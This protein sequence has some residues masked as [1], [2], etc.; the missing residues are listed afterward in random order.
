MYVTEN[1]P[2][3]STIMGS[4]SPRCT[5]KKRPPSPPKRQ[6]SRAGDN[7]TDVVI[8]CSGPVPK[9]SSSTTSSANT[10]VVTVDLHSTAS[11][12]PSLSLPA[13]PSG[14]ELTGT[15]DDELPLPPPPAPSSPPA[16]G[17]REKFEGLT[18]NSSPPTMSRS[19]GNV[20]DSSGSSDQ[21]SSATEQEL[22][23]SLAMQQSRN[24]SDASFKVNIASSN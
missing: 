19:W 4:D 22:I 7:G 24:G 9:A 13:Y 3:T 6:S 21:H 10:T 16:G 23:A 1:V 5:P 17:L 11:S 15:E 20:S 8:D 12:S 18:M 14:D 2:P